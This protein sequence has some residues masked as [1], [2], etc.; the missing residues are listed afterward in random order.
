MGTFC[1][2]YL[3]SL[4]YSSP[5]HF[6]INFFVMR[7][8][9]LSSY[10][11]IYNTSA[12]NCSCHAV[13]SS[14]KTSPFIN[15]YLLTSVNSFF[16]SPPSHLP[17]TTAFLLLVHLFQILYTNATFAF[18]A[19]LTMYPLSSF[20]ASQMIR[21]PS[22]GS[23]LFQGIY[24]LHFENWFFWVPKVVSVP[25]LLETMLPGAWETIHLYCCESLP[26][27]GIAE[28]VRGILRLFSKWLC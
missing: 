25:W 22:Y 27:S 7:L 26:R 24:S 3:G 10:F 5:Y 15:L 1:D 21:F 11:E 4:T 8:W 12:I 20:S 16:S 9:K 2:D 13:W 17:E 14:T 19:R 23:V 6:F 28:C 18:H